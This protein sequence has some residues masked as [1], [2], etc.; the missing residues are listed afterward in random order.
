MSETARRE[1]MIGVFVVAGL[2]L[3]GL[4]FWILE[5]QAFQKK[6]VVEAEFTYAGG[7]R[8]GTP[9]HMAGKPIGA[10]KAVTFRETEQQVVVDVAME[11]E[12][13]YQ[14]KTDSKLTVGSVGLLGEKILEFSLG[15]R[16]A[17]DLPKDGKARLKGDTPPGLEELQQDLSEAVADIKGTIVKVNAFLD[18]LNEPEFK[19]AL[20][21]AIVGLEQTATKASAAVDKVDGFMTGANEFVGKAN[22]AADGVNKVV[23]DAGEVV[24]KLDEIAAKLSQLVD[25]VGTQ[26]TRTGDNIENLA[27]SLDENSKKLN[28]VL[29]QVDGLVKEAREGKGTVGA[30]LSDKGTARKLDDLLVSLKATSDSLAATSDFL[31]KDP[32]SLVWGR[33]ESED[34]EAEEKAAKEADWRDRK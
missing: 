16:S 13:Q 22:T 19:A 15:T 33:S 27:K 10:V 11:I 18:S 14:I 8:E 29:A 25:D 34:E 5:R 7:I 3:V 24:K 2:G 6:Y 1:V 9:V 4:M 17:Q 26:V 23:A 12:W 28:E 32:S 31:R 20:K 30:L 21:G